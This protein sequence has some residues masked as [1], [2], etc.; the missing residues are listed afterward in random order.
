MRL[1]SSAAGAGGE[2]GLLLP[3]VHTRAAESLRSLGWFAGATGSWSGRAGRGVGLEEKNT[4]MV[5]KSRE[6]IRAGSMDLLWDNVY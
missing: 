4:D 3:A 2:Q 6:G 1:A 5:A